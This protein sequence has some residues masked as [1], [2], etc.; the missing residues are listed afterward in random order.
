MNLTRSMARPRRSRSPRRVR[1]SMRR[2]EA[3]PMPVETQ[4]TYPSLDG[5]MLAGTMVEPTVISPESPPVLLVH[6]ITADRHESGFFSAIAAALAERGVP[7]LRFDLRAH[8]DS[9]GAMETVTIHGCVSDISASASWL[10]QH[11]RVASRPALIGASF[12]GGLA[13]LFAA[14]HPVARLTLLNPN[15]DFRESWF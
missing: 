6:G 15:L 11:L 7:S 12:G 4:V 2:P 3:S 14:R 13:V 10:T 1:S 5:L 8:G 9:Q